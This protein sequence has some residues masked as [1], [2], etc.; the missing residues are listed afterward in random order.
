MNP[1]RSRTV[2]SVLAACALLACA[3][4]AI[5]SNT[6]TYQGQLSQNGLPVTGTRNMAFSL[7]NSANGGAQVGATININNVPIDDGIFK[8]ELSFTGEDVGATTT[9][10]WIQ[11]TVEGNILA[12]RQL[13]TASPYSLQT[14]GIYVNNAGDVGIGTT[15]PTSTVHIK[16]TT[17]TSAGQP[18]VSLGLEWQ[19]AVVGTPPR[20]WLSFRVGG[21]PLLPA[22]QDGSHIVRD[23]D[24]KLHF[25]T[26]ADIAGSLDAPQMTLDT[27]G[28]LGI[29]ETDPQSMVDVVG[30]GTIPVMHLNGGADTS[31]GGGGI[32]NMGPLNGINMSMDINEIMVRN[33]GAPSTIFLNADGGDVRFGAARTMPAYAYGRISSTGVILSASSNVTGVSVSGNAFT[34]AIAGF[35]ASTDIYLASALGSDDSCSVSASGSNLIVY[36]QDLSVM[37]DGI[38][39]GGFWSPTP[40]SFNFV[41]YKP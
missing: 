10:R 41:V 31:L 7:W 19:G 12:P 26:Q 14:R 20:D 39:S 22:G 5:G 30:I 32:L 25:T 40:L 13:L 8:V 24:S 4:F 29:N 38:T 1:I 28:R 34:I 2:R 17:P 27:N 18:P 21:T 11:I 36:T 23:D 37:I 6:I 35:N 3:R 16:K 15:A 33:N 9:N